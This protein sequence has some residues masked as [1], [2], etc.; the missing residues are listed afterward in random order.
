MEREREG[1]GSYQCRSQLW[2]PSYSRP[3]WRP[4]RPDWG[5]SRTH[6]DT[7]SLANSQLG[8]NLPVQA[9]AEVSSMQDLM[10][11]RSS[12]EVCSHFPPSTEGRLEAPP[13]TEVQAGEE[14]EL[15]QFLISVRSLVRAEQYQQYKFIS[16]IY[17][18][19]TYHNYIYYSYYIFPGC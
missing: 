12:Q 6:L 5:S 10:G 11:A 4:A 14:G 8:N 19:I 16:K 15:K 13:H 9:E 18:P 17:M 7:H 1:S 3:G 2:G